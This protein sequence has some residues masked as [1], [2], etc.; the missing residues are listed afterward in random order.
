MENSKEIEQIINS[1]YLNQ[2]ELGLVFGLKQPQYH[3][4]FLI[5]SKID[6]E[7]L[8][9]W[10]IYPNRIRIETALKIQKISMKQLKER[11]SF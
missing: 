11:W 1:G 8:G 3:K 2:K 9:D 5:G 10:R 4:V 6:D 7:E